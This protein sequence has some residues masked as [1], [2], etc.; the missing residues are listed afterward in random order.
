MLYNILKSKII[1][2]FNKT[3]KNVIQYLLKSKIILYFNKT[4]WYIRCNVIQYL[5][6]SK[7]ILYSKVIE[8]I[9][10]DIF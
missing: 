9:L 4:F 8:K 3:F 6:K 7:I 2:Y 10:Y 5:L 1:L